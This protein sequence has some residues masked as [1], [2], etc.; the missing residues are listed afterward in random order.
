MV[1]VRVPFRRER[2]IHVRCTMAPA[3]KR[4]N[5]LARG[6]GSQ[7]L[8]QLNFED[9]Q[10]EMGNILGRQTS[11]DNVSLVRTLLLL[12]SDRPYSDPLFHIAR[13]FLFYR[14][15]LSRISGPWRT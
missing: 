10:N 5:S 2:E 12:F 13:S 8:M 14:T 3:L 1:S 4:Q 7:N 11:L 6:G 9:L 15:N